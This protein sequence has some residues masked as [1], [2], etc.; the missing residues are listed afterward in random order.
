M[1]VRYQLNMTS[2]EHDILLKLAERIKKAGGICLTEE[3]VV[4]A[5]LAALRK[6]ACVRQAVTEKVERRLK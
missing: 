1:T 2:K 6:D 3:Q 5:A 4:E